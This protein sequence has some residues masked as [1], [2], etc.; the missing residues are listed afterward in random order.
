MHTPYRG[1]QITPSLAEALW[2]VVE[3]VNGQELSSDVHYV[4]DGGAL[5]QRVP[6]SKGETFE[7][8]CER[9]VEYVS[10]RYG[11]AMIVFDGYES[12]PGIKDVTHRRRG[13]GAGPSVVLTP[14]TVVSLRKKDF[15][16][17]KANKQRFLSLLG[18]FQGKAGCSTIHAKAEAD[19]PIVETAVQVAKS[20]TAVLVGDDT[21]L[22]V[23]LFYHVDMDGHEVF[24]RPEPKATAK[25]M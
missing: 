25:K 11:K 9:Y 10:R 15:L 8:I 21:D 5:L 3:K 2:K 18:S 23:L 22:L 13:H 4:L 7:A 12:G 19:V 16:A 20:T 24:F 6:W 17:N 1:Q 14:Q